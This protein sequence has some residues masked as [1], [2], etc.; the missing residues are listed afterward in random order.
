MRWQAAI[1]RR[2]S[3][4]QAADESYGVVEERRHGKELYADGTRGLTRLGCAASL[5]DFK[6]PYF[7]EIPSSRSAVSV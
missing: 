3:Q 4:N 7:G 6:I 5:M 2:Q 1:A